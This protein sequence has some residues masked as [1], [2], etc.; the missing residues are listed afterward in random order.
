MPLAR[1]KKVLITKDDESLQNAD[2]EAPVYYIPQTGEIFKDYSSFVSRM[3]FYRLKIFQCETSGRGNL[4]FFEA[5]ESE[6]SEA[7]MLDARFPEQLKAA[8][9]KSVQWQ[10]VGRLDHL[11]EAVFDRFKDRY[12]EGERVFVD[13]STSTMEDESKET[14]GRGRYWVRITRVIPPAKEQTTNGK[15][16]ASQMESNDMDAF[17]IPHDI[18]GDLKIPAATVNEQDDPK[19]YVYETQL[20]EEGPNGTYT[21]VQPAT[22]GD[23]RQ[24]ATVMNLHCDVLSRDRLAF[25]KSILKRFIRECVDRDAAVASPW[26]VKNEIA[27]KYQITQQMPDDVRKGVDAVKR[28]ESEKRKRVSEVKE[29]S[30]PVKRAK[31]ATKAPLTEEEKVAK[32]RDE[33][34]AKVKRE[35]DEANRLLLTGCRR[36]VARWP[37]ED[38]DVVLTQAEKA[39]GKP[40]CRPTGHSTSEF[41]APEVFESFIMSWNFVTT[42]GHAFNVSPF[43]LDTL[44]AAL[45]HSGDEPCHL[46]DVLHAGIIS[47]CRSVSAGMVKTQAAVQSLSQEYDENEME[48]DEGVDITT[49]VTSLGAFG[50]GWE[51]KAVNHETWCNAL[52]SILKEHATV[53]N[54]PTLRQILA[55]LLFKPAAR[56]ATN[57][58]S[59]DVK[60]APGIKEWVAAKPRERYYSLSFELKVAILAFLC[61][62]SATSKAVHNALDTC[63]ATLTE[64][65]KEKIELKRQQKKLADQI[66][67]MAPEKRK[68]LNGSAVPTNGKG[69]KVSGEM[70]NE[71]DTPPESVGS[72]H[73]TEDLVTAAVA[74]MTM[75]TTPSEAASDDNFASFPMLDG[76]STPAKAGSRTPR[77]SLRFKAQDQARVVK[78]KEEPRPLT[79]QEEEELR[80][81]EEEAAK[82]DR[83]L[84]TLELEFRQYL[85][86]SRMRPMGEDRF[87]CK[88]WWFDGVGCMTLLDQDGQHLYGTGKLFI[89]APSEDD[90]SLI[91]A[92]AAVEPSIGSRRAEEEGDGLLNV[93]Q[94]AWYETPEEF[95]EYVSWLNPKGTRESNLKSNLERWKP[96]IVGGMI[97]RHKELMLQSKQVGR[98]KS[99]GEIR[100]PYMNYV[101]LYA[102]K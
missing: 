83:N 53:Q 16:K 29:H 67:A 81:Y 46:I 23:F 3:S 8:V 55:H 74:G 1:R 14:P 44:E 79:K 88:V 56:D 80:Q 61:D 47:S 10:I 2:G 86:L 42:Y 25:S 30:S 32:A 11:V 45:N 54:M 38:L 62:L 66:A 43:S 85:L 27:L 15:R 37:I 65:R 82:V 96:Y 99:N 50:S 60:P 89:Q 58:A 57:G 100:V 18:Y 77:T 36:H 48:T 26:V 98:R 52:V 93:G 71:G 9:L 7:R 72:E 31:R 76:V 78:K 17:V 87:H 5:L 24:G 64:M 20:V 34:A 68:P 4:T 92:K 21:T 91:D 63:E 73:G 69:P 94:W 95:E 19:A 51:K 101:N 28:T 102:T 41:S 84:E 13:F 49:L 6:K 59:G 90:I 35:R 75:E 33:E 12:F 39:S 97:A 40:I 70:M 22:T